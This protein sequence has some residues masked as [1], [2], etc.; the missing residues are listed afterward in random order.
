MKLSKVQIH[1]DF[2]PQ[3]TVSVCGSIIKQMNRKTSH[4]GSRY[5]EYAKSEETV[6]LQ[7]CFSVTDVNIRPISSHHRNGNTGFQFVSHK[8]RH[9]LSVCVCVCVSFK[10]VD[11]RFPTSDECLRMMSY[12]NVQSTVTNLHWYKSINASEQSDHLWLV[13]RDWRSQQNSFLPQIRICDK[14]KP[15]SPLLIF[16]FTCAFRI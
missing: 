16:T 3:K 10:A 7:L 9:R 13:S 4:D 11:W 1:L 5:K 8:W 15:L 2:P 12:T 14:T 6:E